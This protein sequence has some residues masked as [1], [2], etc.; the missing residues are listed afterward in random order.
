MNPKPFVLLALG[1]ALLSPSASAQID[2]GL[3]ADIRL[4]RTPPP[5]PPEVVVIESVP[6]PGPPSWARSRLFHR[7]REYYY[8]P[9]ADVYYRPADR[10]WFYLDGGGWRFAG[11]LP[12]TVHVEFD[13]SVR[14]TLATDRP[15]EYNEKVRAYY[16]RDYFISRVRIKDRPGQ[17]WDRHRDDRRDDHR[18]D[19]NRR[20]DDRRDNDRDHDRGRNHD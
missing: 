10:T 16:P 15:Y 14:V 19:D 4:G 3:S 7:S 11:N 18:R 9:A 17:P 13:R 20:D 2:L 8:Y 12:P 1:A 5:P 6:P